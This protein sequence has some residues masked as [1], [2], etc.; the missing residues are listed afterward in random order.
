MTDTWI[1]S[2]LGDNL[3]IMDGESVVVL[4]W[5]KT[6]PS[7]WCAVSKMIAMFGGVDTTYAALSATPQATAGG[8]E[9]Y[10]DD[11]KSQGIIA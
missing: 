2:T 4:E 7:Q 6:V 10:F 11:W 9:K 3:R 1:T 8:W 5:V